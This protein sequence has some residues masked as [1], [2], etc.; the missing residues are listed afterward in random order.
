VAG[1]IGVFSIVT[2]A[3]AIG[4][5]S[6]SRTCPDTLCDGGC[7]GDRYRIEVTA[8]SGA[9]TDSLNENRSASCPKWFSIPIV[10]WPGV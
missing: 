4:W 8:G 10:A 2:V 7:G 5:L 3:F 9:S 1:E 6:L